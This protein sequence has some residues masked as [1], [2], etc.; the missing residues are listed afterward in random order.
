MKWHNIILE[1]D[2]LVAVQALRSP[3]IMRSWFGDLNSDCK[4][5]LK[6][7]PFVKV[8]FIKRSAN[9][10]AHSVARA[11][12]SYPDCIFDLGN[13]PIALLSPLVTHIDS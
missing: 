4:S 5:L 9:A 3:I 6:E 12:A 2:C 7:L 10:A 1:T 8:V 11:S 13:I